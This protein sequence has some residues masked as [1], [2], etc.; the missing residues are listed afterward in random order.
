MSTFYLVTGMP[1]TFCHLYPHLST[2]LFWEVCGWHYSTGVMS[3]GVLG[4]ERG[5][6][7][8]AVSTGL[9]M[10]LITWSLAVTCVPR[11]LDR[12]SRVAISPLPVWQEPEIGEMVQGSSGPCAETSVQAGRSH[13][14][15][16][17]ALWGHQTSG[18]F[19]VTAP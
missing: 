7:A 4:T 16:A 19:Q 14:L 18:T 10:W 9:C 2:L 13:V 5:C 1:L 12:K 3:I 17:L 6:R 15:P 8:V 11:A